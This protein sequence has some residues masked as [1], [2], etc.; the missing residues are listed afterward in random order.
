[1]HLPKPPDKPARDLDRGQDL[2]SI[3]HDTCLIVWKWQGGM[4]SIRAA[5]C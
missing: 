4:G 5:P 2:V 3:L 1:M